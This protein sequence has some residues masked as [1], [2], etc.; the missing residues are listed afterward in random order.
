M[1]LCGKKYEINKWSYMLKFKLIFIDAHQCYIADYICLTLYDCC[2]MF[3]NL[4]CIKKVVFDNV[5]CI[6]EHFCN[7]F[8]YSKVKCITVLFC[9]VF[10]YSNMQILRILFVSN[11]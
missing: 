1:V 8:L 7:A 10:P 11:I 4:I 6:T 5:K 3:H 2:I 9:N